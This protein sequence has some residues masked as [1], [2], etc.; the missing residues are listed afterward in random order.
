MPIVGEVDVSAILE[1][2]GDPSH[3][4]KPAGSKEAYI[5][6]EEREEVYRASWGE[7]DMSTSVTIKPVP[8][9]IWDVN[10]YYRDLGF[11]WPFRPTRR[12]LRLAYQ[13][14]NGQDSERLTYCFKQLLQPAIRAAYD[15][16]PLGSRYDDKY[17]KEENKRKLGPIAKEVSEEEGRLVTV[18]ELVERENQAQRALRELPPPSKNYIWNWGYYAYKSRKYD[19][20]I[21]EQWQT[22]LVQ[23]FAS[24]GLAVVISI[25]YIGEVDDE[26]VIKTHEGKTVI[27]LNENTHPTIE[28]AQTAVSKYKAHRQKG[29]S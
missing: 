16:T 26:I 3:G 14:L 25:G 21:L 22:L 11:S 12:E 1:K 13:A 5:P 2:L 19:P 28:L 4:L 18:D 9:V 24:R 15:R 7:S 20:E 8:V 6:Q 29:K 10:N 17:V 27:F 23:E